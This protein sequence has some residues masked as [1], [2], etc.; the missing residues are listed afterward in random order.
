[1]L[2]YQGMGRS[3]RWCD[4]H[5]YYIHSNWKIEFLVTRVYFIAMVCLFLNG[6]CN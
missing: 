3:I 1:M 5:H 4:D 2:M 6:R